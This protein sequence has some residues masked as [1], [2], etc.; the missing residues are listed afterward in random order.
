M[1]SFLS[2][3]IKDYIN[4]RHF[5][6]AKCDSCSAASDV[7]ICESSIILHAPAI[8]TIQLLRFEF[9]SPVICH[10]KM[11]P[12]RCHDQ[13]RLPSGDGRHFVYQHRST[14][15]HVGRNSTSCHYIAYK[16][17][18]G[19][20][21]QISDSNCLE[22]READFTAAALSAGPNNETPYI[23]IYDRVA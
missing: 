9:I 17:F 10:K 23:L 3:L 5:L 18:Q 12:V 15:S 4:P 16:K 11:C 7:D 8:L 14:V 13:I 1:L 20:F 6:K 19:R 21:F 2:G 22:M